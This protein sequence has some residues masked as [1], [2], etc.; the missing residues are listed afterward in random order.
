MPNIQQA[1][2]FLLLLVL[3]VTTETRFSEG[4]QL[5]DMKECEQ[6]LGSRKGNQHVPGQDNVFHPESTTGNQWEINGFQHTTLGHSPGVCH[7]LGNL[8][9]PNA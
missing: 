5:K 3:T 7:S 1:Y 8:K 6:S 9:D 4:R 2:M